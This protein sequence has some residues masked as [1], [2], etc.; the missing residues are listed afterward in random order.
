LFDISNNQSPDSMLHTRFFTPRDHETAIAFENNAAAIA[1]ILPDPKE[2]LVQQVFHDNALSL[3]EMHR[4]NLERGVD[5]LGKGIAR[6]DDELAPDEWIVHR[7][8]LLYNR[9]RL[10]AALGRHDEAFDGFTRLIELD[11]YYTDYLCERAK[12]SRLRGDLA[13]ALTDYD[14][15]VT[16]AP[17]F[18]EVHYNRG[19]ARLETGDVAGA[20]VD[21]DYVL[22]MEPDGR[23]N[24]VAAGRVAVEPR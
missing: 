23:T 16:M 7:S 15:A 19:A 18:P 17:P 5:L 11:P 13:T 1:S 21:F 4:G 20:R 9:T 12:V 3:I 6:L 10:L 22:E 8:Q 24:S 14:R 2:R